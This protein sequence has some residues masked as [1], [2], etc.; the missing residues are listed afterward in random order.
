MVA[1]TH[2]KAEHERRE[3]NASR[4]FNRIRGIWGMN[5]DFSFLQ[6]ALSLLTY[7]LPQ[8]FPPLFHPLSP[9]RNLRWVF[10]GPA[11]AKLSIGVTPLC[12]C[13]CMRTYSSCCSKCTIK[14]KILLCCWHSINSTVKRSI[15]MS[16]KT[17]HYGR[18]L[19][20]SFNQSCTSRM[21]EKL[22][23][24]AFGCKS[25]WLYIRLNT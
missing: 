11:C 25:V 6:F 16:N 3:T 7:H 21:H 5:V 17:S 19:N 20:F 12:A 8:I 15:N 13:V 9:D 10:Q 1:I 2:E 18:L 24:S 23:L 22:F 14:V 4:P